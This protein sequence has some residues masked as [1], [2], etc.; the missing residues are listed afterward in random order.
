MKKVHCRDCKYVGVI[1][2]LP[3]MIENAKHT[4]RYIPAD[5]NKPEGRKTIDPKSLYLNVLNE[6]GNCPYYKRKWWKFWVKN[7]PVIY[8]VQIDNEGEK[9]TFKWKGDKKK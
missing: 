2:C 4:I 1:L 5:P 6:D 8:K 7:P 9:D 3:Q